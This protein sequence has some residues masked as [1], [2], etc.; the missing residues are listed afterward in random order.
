MFSSR[1]CPLPHHRHRVSCRSSVRV[2]MVHKVSADLYLTACYISFVICDGLKIVKTILLF[3]SEL[4][5]L[6]V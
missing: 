6:K 5:L 1:C 3:T 4:E 2:Y